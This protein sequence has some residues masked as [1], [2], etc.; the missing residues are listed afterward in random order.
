MRRTVFVSMVAALLCGS[1]LY[2]QTGQITGTV[3]S[4]EGGRPIAG[5]VVG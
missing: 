1:P 4:S 5:A 3:T 2:A